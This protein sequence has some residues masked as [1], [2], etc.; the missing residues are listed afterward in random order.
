MAV[1]RYDRAA[2]APIINTYVPID[3]NQ[4]Y[5]IGVTQKQEIDRAAEQMGEAIRTFGTFRSPSRVDT[6]NYYKETLGKLQ[7]YIQA[8]AADPDR[9]KDAAFRSSVQAAIN[10]LNY[11][12]ISQLQENAANLRQREANVAK[13]IAAGTYNPNWDMYADIANYN[14]L[15]NGVLTELAPIAYMDAATLSNKYYNDLQPGF[16]GQV[17]RNGVRYN[18]IGNNVEDLRAIA[19]AHMSD[20]ISTPQGQMYYREFLQAN[21]EDADKAQQAFRDMIVASQIDKTIRPKYEVDPVWLMQ[22]KAAASGSGKKST[23]FMPMRLNFIRSSFMSKSADNIRQVNSEQE[24]EK[25]AKAEDTLSQALIQAARAYDTNPTEQNLIAMQEA[26]GALRELQGSFI[27]DSNRKVMANKFREVT[28]Y[29]PYEQPKEFHSKN[30]LKGVGS[31][32]SSVETSLALSKDD[33]VISALGAIPT[34][35]QE[36][37]NDTKPAYQFNSSDGFILPETAYQM[38]G[39]SNNQQ[40]VNRDVKRGGWFFSENDLGFR[41]ALESGRFG[42]VQFIPSPNIIQIGTSTYAIKGKIRISEEE[43]EQVLGTGTYPLSTYHVSRDSSTP[44]S[45]LLGTERL[46]NALYAN[47]D[48]KKIKEKVGEDDTATYYEFDTYRLLPDAK[49]NKEWW[50]YVSQMWQNSPSHGGMGGAG[51]ANAAYS[52]TAEQF[53]SE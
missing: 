12:N 44:A 48:A 16:I 11:T 19:D 39:S 49:T 6:E 4:L 1:N 22:A 28:G 35:I 13:M 9:M 43:L 7:P 23:D 40:V 21:N 29:S 25:Q 2:E 36:G 5:R 38:I 45:G 14:T 34:E 31:A 15:E 17:N 46:D 8:A 20:L 52:P 10:G 33:A 27:L 41:Q 47:Y 51:Q 24:L 32:L 50:M 30:F 26:E 42:T 53:L 37:E 3:F 18:V